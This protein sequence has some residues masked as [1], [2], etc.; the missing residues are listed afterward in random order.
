VASREEECRREARL[1]VTFGGRPPAGEDADDAKFSGAGWRIFRGT[2][3]RVFLNG[4]Y[5]PNCAGLGSRARDAIFA[6]PFC[7]AILTMADSTASKSEISGAAAQDAGERRANLIS[8]GVEDAGQQGFCRDQNRGVQ[9]PPLRAPRSAKGILER[10][11]SSSKPRLRR[12]GHSR[13][14]TQRQDRPGEHGLAVQKKAHAPHSPS[15]AMLRA[16][17][18]EILT[19]DFEESFVGAKETSTC[20]AVQRHRM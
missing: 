20:F 7:C 11:Q 12:S 6:D 16:S 5:P 4:K 3:R 18:A 2:F 1:T 10:M 17:V 8:S 14:R 15:H 13:S 9:Y 19:K